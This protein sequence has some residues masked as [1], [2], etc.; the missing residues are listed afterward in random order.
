MH[1]GRRAKVAGFGEKY[2][3]KAVVQ[4]M[5]DRFALAMSQVN[6]KRL[7]YFAVTARM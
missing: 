3:G 6:G 2:Y 5:L 7:T 1:K 4:G